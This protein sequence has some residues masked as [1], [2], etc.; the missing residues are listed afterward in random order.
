M[1]LSPKNGKPEDATP[2]RR[3]RRRLETRGR[4]M[5]SAVALFAAQGYHATSVDDIARDADVARAT[6]FNYFPRKEDYLTAWIDSRRS[7]FKTFLADDQAAG[8]DTT[9]RLL[10]AFAGLAAVYEHDPEISRPIVREW[11]RTGGPL[12]AHGA[13]SAALV[14][15]VLAEGQHRGDIR[16]DIDATE[17]GGVVLDIYYGALYSWAREDGLPARLAEP[18]VRALG[19]MLGAIQVRRGQP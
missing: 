1:D 5:R 6:A 17:M 18:V 9:A 4:L 8:L 16:P 19:L 2:T 14:G 3:D 12:M 13:G 10:H 15:S 11:L 7:D